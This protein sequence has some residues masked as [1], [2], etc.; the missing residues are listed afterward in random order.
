MNPFVLKPT[1]R[2]MISIGSV[3][4]LAL[5]L[6]GCESLEQRRQRE[7]DEDARKCFRYGT[8]EGSRAHDDC[9]YRQQQRRDRDRDE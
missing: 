3:V 2:R 4:I 1:T 9:M 8:R 6:V 5:T 7:R